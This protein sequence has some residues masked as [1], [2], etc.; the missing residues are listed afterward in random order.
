[1]RVL[2]LRG[3][4]GVGSVGFSNHSAYFIMVAYLLMVKGGN[5]YQF[6]FGVGNTICAHRTLC[7]GVP[8]LGSAPTLAETHPRFFLCTCGLLCAVKRSTFSLRNETTFVFSK[9]ACR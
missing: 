8:E 2:P 5:E 6:I 9:R 7:V 1:M 4:T 3:H